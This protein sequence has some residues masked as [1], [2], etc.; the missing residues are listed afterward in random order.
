MKSPL[1]PPK[2]WTDDALTNYLDD[3]HRNRF[4]TF[5]NMRPQFDKLIGIDRLLWELISG[6]RD[7]EHP[8]PLLFMFR[9]MSAYRVTCQNACAGQIL[10]TFVAARGCLEFA[11]YEIMILEKPDRATVWFDRHSGSKEHQGVKKEFT[12]GSVKRAIKTYSPI[13]SG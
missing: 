10:E 12:V 3:A 1:E 9:A 6:F 5:A 2:G 11:G 8:I 4:A 13:L 7:P